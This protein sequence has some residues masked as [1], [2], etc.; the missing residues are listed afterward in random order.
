L[1][2]SKGARKGDEKNLQVVGTTNT[3]HVILSALGNLLIPMTSAVTGAATAQK[4]PA[5]VPPSIPKLFANIQITKLNTPHAN[6]MELAMF[7]LPIESLKYPIGGLPN[8]C[9]KFSRAPIILPCCA[10]SPMVLA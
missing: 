1:R 2:I 3:N 6:V 7:S 10:V 4:V 9:P 5:T 8:A